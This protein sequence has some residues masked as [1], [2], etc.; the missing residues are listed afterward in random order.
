MRTVGKALARR[1]PAGGRQTSN[2]H[3]LCSG[4][5]QQK[6]TSCPW[7]DIR[8]NVLDKVGGFSG[9]HLPKNKHP[10]E[11]G[12]NRIRPANKKVKPKVPK[13]KDRDSA[14]STSRTQ[15]IM[16]QVM[17]KGRLQ[18]PAATLSL[19]AGQTVELRCKGSKIGWSYPA[20]L[21][22]FKD[23]RLRLLHQMQKTVPNT[24]AAPAPSARGA[25]SSRLLCPGAWE[26]PRHV[27]VFHCASSQ[28]CCYLPFR[29]PF[30]SHPYC[31][32]SA[33]RGLE[34]FSRVTHG[35][36]CELVLLVSGCE[37][38]AEPISGRRAQLFTTCGSQG[39]VSS[40]A[41]RR[42]G[43]LTPLRYNDAAG[44]ETCSSEG[45]KR[46]QQ[47]LSLCLPSSVPTGSQG[48]P[49]G[50]QGA[51]DIIRRKWGD[52]WDLIPI[53]SFLEERLPLSLKEA[54][55]GMGVRGGSR[56]AGRAGHA[57][58]CRAHRLGGGRPT[59]GCAQGC[60]AD[61]AAGKTGGSGRI[62]NVKQQERYG[63]LTLVNST[64]ADTGEF[65]CW[66]QL[67]NGY[68]CRRDET[69]T[70]STYIFF[71][72]KGELFVPSP[73]YFDV[74][75]LNP[76]RQAV[77]PCRVT[78][79]SAKVTLHREF[80][81][82]EI[83]ANG[84]DITY[85]L[86]RG[87]VYLQPHSDHQGVV[88]CKAEAGDKSQISV[89]YQLLYVEV[90]SGP[91]STTIS[92][93][94]NRVRGGEDVR[95]L[96]TVLGEPEVEVEFRWVFPGQKCSQSAV[97]CGEGLGGQTKRR[98]MQTSALWSR[99]PSVLGER[100]CGQQLASWARVCVGVVKQGE[101]PVTIQDTWRLTQRGLGHTTRLSQSVLTVEDFETTDAGYY[102]CTAQNLRGQTTVATTV[103]LS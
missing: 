56:Q 84:T 9:Q 57:A 19:M 10:K 5:Q 1:E 8:T 39:S 81:A 51:N 59:A 3:L 7:V 91:P 45:T 42:P 24:R 93:S 76:D 38:H 65:S 69:R 94:S 13:I 2:W 4:D 17:D 97:P 14:D 31:G 64:S 102:L 60:R 16:L 88:Y 70:G 78:M 61:I 47:R 12:E 83:P 75:Y 68:I 25:G 18:K 62:R 32:L 101:R 96:C 99:P 50:T 98:G 35:E 86:K 58:E 100:G 30:F 28:R 89:K 63:Q 90:P 53:R 74:V 48:H 72:E 34:I 36:C 37:I 54:V 29:G 15:S 20:Y 95:V 73:S 85:D 26:A 92:A 77:V 27:P 33:L 41:Q 23:S 21:D 82:K 6:V 66:G 40:F 80:P 46:G 49:R 87:F 79:L 71:T 67:C 43:F 103:E 22:T 52:S 11:P 55:G 44:P